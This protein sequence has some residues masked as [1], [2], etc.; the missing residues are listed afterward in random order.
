MILF[1]IYNDVND[2]RK[3]EITWFLDK[4]FY[5]WEKLNFDVDTMHWIVINFVKWLC[6][7]KNVKWTSIIKISA[8]LIM[9]CDC[10]DVSILHHFSHKI[11]SFRNETRLKHF[12]FNF[13]WQSHK[14]NLYTLLKQ[15]ELFH[16]N[17][18]IP[19]W[20][21][22]LFCDSWAL[23]IFIFIH[24][25]VEKSWTVHTTLFYK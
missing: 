23:L 1:V 19:M 14:I 2:S 15:Y 17:N 11:E 6:D 8:R 18:K 5:D 3:I 12:F 25:F 7:H 20:L 13:D 24:K 9:L 4:L 22:W 16:H 21:K 10:C